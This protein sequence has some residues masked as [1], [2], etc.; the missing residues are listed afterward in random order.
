M[1]YDSDLP[2]SSTQFAWIG[3]TDREDEG[4]WK[5]LD[6]TEANFVP[7]FHGKSK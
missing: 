3:F 6:E 5:F 4:I 2:V 1:L 7:Q